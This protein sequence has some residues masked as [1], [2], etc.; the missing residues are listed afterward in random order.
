MSLQD[1]FLDPSKKSTLSKDWE[2][3]APFLFSEQ[4]FLNSLSYSI[5]LTTVSLLFFHMTRVHSIEL[6]HFYSSFFSI[7]LIIMS[8]AY[9]VLGLVQYA[10]RLAQLLLDDGENKSLISKERDYWYTYLSLGILFIMM[11]TFLCFVIVKKS[12]FP[13]KVKN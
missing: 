1:T 12:L 5:L 9:V 6:P 2:Q 11:E 4:S 10:Q 3:F 8:I 7:I 13:N